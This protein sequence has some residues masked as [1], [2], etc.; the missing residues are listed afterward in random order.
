MVK[1]QDEIDQLVNS[2]IEDECELLIG[3]VQCSVCNKVTS[4]VYFDVGNRNTICF[5]CIRD[6]ARDD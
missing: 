5:D 6:E 2:F 4:Q 1:S 3:H